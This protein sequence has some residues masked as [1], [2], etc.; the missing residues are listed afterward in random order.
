MLFRFILAG[1]LVL[2]LATPLRAELLSPADQNHYRAALDSVRRGKY[3]DALKH[4]HRAHDKL[5]AKAIDWMELTRQGSGRSFSDIVAFHDHNPDWPGLSTLRMRAE[6]AIA[7]L[8]DA[9]LR[10]WFRRFPPVTAF[11]RLRQADLLFA[12]GKRDDAVALVRSVW[13]ESDFGKAEEKLVLQRYHQY[14]RQE[15]QI[16]RLDRQVWDG[17]EDGAKRQYAR[18]P[19]DWKEVAE[20]R[21]QLARLASNALK[22]VDKVPPSLRRDPG[23]LYEKARYYRRKDRFQDATEIVAGAPAEAGRPTAW[24]TE[25]QILA[26]RALLEGDAKLAYRL[27][28]R[29]GL[30]RG[31]VPYL[32]GEFL[33]G[34][35]AL[36]FLKDAP[37]S[38]THFGHLHDAATMP[39]SIA[40]GAYWAG[41][42]AEARNDREGAARWYAAAAE[43]Q[44]TYYGQLAR[45]RLGKDAPPK[46]LPEPAPTAQEIAAFEKKELVRIARMLHELGVT[47]KAKPF[48]LRLSDLA[49]T[50]S[51]HAL[52]ARLA[53]QLGRPD[54]EVSV[55]KR[56]S[57]VGVALMLH[58]YPVIPMG[59]GGVSERPLVLA[60][61]RQESAFDIDAVSGA[62]ALGLMQLMPSTAKEIAKAQGVKF[63]A[64]RLTRDPSYNLMLGRAYLDGLLDSFGGSYVLS[65]AAYNAGPSRVRQWTRDY[66]DP[67][68]PD[69]DVVDWVESIP[70]NETRNYV[71]RVLENLQV[72][73]VRMG[74]SQL[75]F[76][77]SDDLRR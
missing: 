49:K 30:E 67:R 53:E 28:A 44:A 7:G 61:T 48:V 26:R 68:A 13:V 9:D 19:A 38:Y 35:I 42:A 27:A 76:S 77:I 5:L 8:P 64:A 66:G 36:R 16:R 33:A 40:R 31:S 72:Y 1:L 14:L 17:N 29:H 18:V 43:H 2:S 25:R 51:D 20:A 46:L 55:G 54:L 24:W 10:A 4:A 63:S 62:G 12:D 56:A 47:D 3:D 59:R 70:V 73:R 58:G 71:Q 37:T 50:P 6:D 39:I 34:W 60:M 74:D 11:A 69:I 57:Y 45:A 75:A 41:R 22:L 15:D 21:F 32:E 65:I 23:L 52:T